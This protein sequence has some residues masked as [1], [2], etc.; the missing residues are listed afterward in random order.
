MRIKIFVAP[1]ERQQ[2]EAYFNSVYEKNIYLMKPSGQVPQHNGL[3]MGF[4]S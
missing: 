4:V 3:V 1:E 2:L